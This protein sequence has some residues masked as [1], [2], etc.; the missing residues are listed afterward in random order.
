M[1]DYYTSRYLCDILEDMRSCHKIHNYSYLIGL[2]EEAQWAGNR[3][4][5]AIGDIRDILKLKKERAKLRDAIRELKQTK[6]KLGNNT[7][8]SRKR[9]K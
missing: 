3:M 1:S 6:K 8:P 2:I 4:E 5:A 7:K 9:S